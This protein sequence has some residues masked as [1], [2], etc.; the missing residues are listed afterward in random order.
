MHPLRVVAAVVVCH[1]QTFTTLNHPALDTVNHV[2]RTDGPGFER[3]F[4]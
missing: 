4:P 1:V 2:R 3:T